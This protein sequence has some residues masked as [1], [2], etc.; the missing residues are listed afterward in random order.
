M[1][2]KT[3]VRNVWAITKKWEL[4]RIQ[5]RSFEHFML[6]DKIILGTSTT[7]SNHHLIQF[8]LPP[9]PPISIYKKK[10]QSLYRSAFSR[11]ATVFNFEQEENHYA[12]RSKEDLKRWVY[13]QLNACFTSFVWTHCCTRVEDA[14]EGWP[15]LSTEQEQNWLWGWNSTCSRYQYVESLV[16]ISEEW[17]CTGITS[18]SAGSCR[19]RS[20]RPWTIIF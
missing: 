4:Q 1:N 5:F 9:I 8:V 20:E 13:V 3:R 12:T 14:G 10:H 2:K 19:M 6:E 15:N 7:A 11:I 16:G 18:P 17:K